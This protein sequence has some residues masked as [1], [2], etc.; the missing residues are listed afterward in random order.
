M[1][2][3]QEA[4]LFC[5]AIVMCYNRQTTIRVSG[6]VPPPITW[7]ICQTMVDYLNHI[8]NACVLKQFAGHWLLFDGLNSTIIMSSKSKEEVNVRPSFEFLMDDDLG[9]FFELTSL[10]SNIRSKVFGVLDSFF[11]L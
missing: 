10:V 6:R 1:I 11:H 8:F 5:G 3:F 9:I 4:F 2:L 7:F